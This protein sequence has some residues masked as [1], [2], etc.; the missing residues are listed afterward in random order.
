[1]NR[2]AISVALLSTLALGCASGQPQI[3][4]V[5]QPS[6]D[7]TPP[8]ESEPASAGI[9]IALLNPQYAQPVPAEWETASDE[10]SRNLGLDL[11]EMLTA[12]GFTVLGPFRNYDQMI[13]SEKAGTDLLLTPSLDVTPRLSDVEIGSSFSLAALGTV[14][15]VEKGTVTV[16]GR[17]TLVVA[18]P[19]TQEKL[20]APSIELEK[21]S[22]TFRGEREYAESPQTLI[23]EPAAISAVNKLLEDVYITLLKKC[24]ERLDPVEF[25]VL[26]QQSHQIRE[27]AGYKIGG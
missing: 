5:Y 27:K 23:G 10:F 12:R 14:Y 16:G 19:F 2:S 13:Y 26:K 6:F 11:E 8:T 24:W 25:A 7:Y 17:V 9:T 18:E 3:A 1:M 22:K 20:W 4:S 15:K 21:I